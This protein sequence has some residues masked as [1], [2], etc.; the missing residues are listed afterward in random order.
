MSRIDYL[1]EKAGND[2][3]TVCYDQAQYYSYFKWNSSKT[4]SENYD[5]FIKFCKNLNRD[6][7]E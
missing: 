6:W 2:G 1:L 5:L 7:N 3:F 4:N